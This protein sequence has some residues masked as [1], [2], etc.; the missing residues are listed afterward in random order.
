MYS[1]KKNKKILL[2]FFICI[3]V[4]SIPILI[5]YYTRKFD[6]L[7]SLLYF[8][9][10]LSFIYRA[11]TYTPNQLGVFGGKVW[12]QKLRILHALS[13]IIVYKLIKENNI[14]IARKL[15]IV[16]LLIGMIKF[17]SVYFK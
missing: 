1:L 7:I 14:D 9:I 3:P 10:S 2:Y 13:Y 6:Y 17:I 5:L 11:Y 12:W 16:D 4:R 15:L 8:F